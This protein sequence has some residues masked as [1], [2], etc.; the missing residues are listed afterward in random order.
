MQQIRLIEE[1]KISKTLFL[2]WRLA[3]QWVCQAISVPGVEY[4]HECAWR[5][6]VTRQ[7]VDATT[8]GLCESGAWRQGVTARR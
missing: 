2:I 1:L 8:V 6:S 3:T 5:Q 4:C 7:A